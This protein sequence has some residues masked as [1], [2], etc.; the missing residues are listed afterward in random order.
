MQK[1]ELNFKELWRA[2][3][4]Q[5]SKMAQFVTISTALNKNQIK[6]NARTE[7]ADLKIYNEDSKDEDMD[8]SSSFLA[9]LRSCRRSNGGLDRRHERKQHDH[10]HDH[11]HQ[12]NRD[13][14]SKHRNTGGSYSRNDGRQ[15]SRPIDDNSADHYQ[16]RRCY[17]NRHHFAQHL[18]NRN[19]QQ[20]GNGHGNRYCLPKRNHHKSD[21][22]FNFS[23]PEH[24]YR[25][26][27]NN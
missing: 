25:H 1:C 3:A 6:T 8:D 21:G 14:Q 27:W 23:Q 26:Y 9:G 7:N 17:W 4:F 19:D 22:Q 5:N 13:Q 10:R 15:Y 11:Q 2:S 12:S 20:H 24:D 16:P 18:S